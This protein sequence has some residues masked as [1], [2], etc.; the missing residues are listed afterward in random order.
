MLCY[1]VLILAVLGLDVT[2]LRSALLYYAE[3]RCAM[4][5]FAK[6]GYYFA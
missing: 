2:A 5:Y 4:L 3:L 6:F 1:A